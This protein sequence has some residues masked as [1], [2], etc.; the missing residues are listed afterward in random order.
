ML[1]IQTLINVKNDSKYQIDKFHKAINQMVSKVVLCNNTTDLDIRKMCFKVHDYEI[2]KMGDVFLI[3]ELD[4]PVKEVFN[5]LLKQNKIVINVKSNVD[6]Q[7]K[8]LKLFYFYV[9]V[10]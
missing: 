1:K 3:G 5:S 8:D 4:G 7:T 9:D 10:I 6:E 2:N